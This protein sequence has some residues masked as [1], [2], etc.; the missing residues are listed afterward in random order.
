M[1]FGATLESITQMCNSGWGDIFNL[2]GQCVKVQI[3]YYSPWIAGFV[4]IL[5]L[6]KAGPYRGYHGAGGYG[7]HN[8]RRRINLTQMG[9]VAAIAIGIVSLYFNY[10][11]H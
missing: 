1:G 6:A 7:S 10:F 3:V 11:K 8:R 4:G 5:F 2:A 9:V